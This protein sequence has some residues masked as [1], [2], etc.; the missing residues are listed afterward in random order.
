MIHILTCQIRILG[1]VVRVL[2]FR[3]ERLPVMIQAVCFCSSGKPGCAQL[4]PQFAAD[5]SILLDA[6]AQTWP[7]S[8]ISTAP[9]HPPKSL[10]PTTPSAPCSRI[11]ILLLNWVGMDIKL[12]TRLTH[13]LHR[14][15]RFNQI[16]YRFRT[17]GPSSVLCRSGSHTFVAKL[18]LLRC[19]LFDFRLIYNEWFV[20]KSSRSSWS[21]T[22]GVLKH[23]SVSAC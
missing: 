23:T 8:A 2:R 4:I 7:L 16:A 14:L 3:S 17:I 1:S 20:T 12:E 6:V 13:E 21:N 22:A 11:E 10:A 18:H 5:P 9:P 15:E 19:C